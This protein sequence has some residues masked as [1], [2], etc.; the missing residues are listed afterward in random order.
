MTQSVQIYDFTTKKVSSIPAAELAPGM[1]EAEVQGIGRVWVAA[2]QL[3]DEGPYRHPPLTE[4][5]RQYLRRIKE[6]LD[7]VYPQTL[8][9]WEDG[10]RKDLHAEREIAIWLHIASTYQRCTAAR[11]LTLHQRRDYFD[12]IAACSSTPREHI[13]EVVRLRALSRKEAVELYYS[14]TK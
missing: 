5:I 12:V 4:D 9:E 11:P 13:F 3:R 6:S 8:E 1:I 7:E 14:P 2:S 10:F